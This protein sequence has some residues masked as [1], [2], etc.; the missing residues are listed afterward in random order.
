MAST[1]KLSIPDSSI[2]RRPDLMGE[3]DSVFEAIEESR[4]MLHWPNNWDGEG[5]PSYDEA[6][7]N[8]VATF[9]KNAAIRLW[10]DEGKVM[11][12]PDIQPGAEGRIVIEWSIDDR[13]LVL[14]IPTHAEEQ[15]EFYGH[16]RDR[17]IAIKGKLDITSPQSTWLLLWTV[18]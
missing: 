12:A 15:A 13:D 3:L 8:R 16:D 18:Q 10:E 9:L 17:T 4:S 7:W 5:S 1:S 11:E 6:T 2:Q 14:A